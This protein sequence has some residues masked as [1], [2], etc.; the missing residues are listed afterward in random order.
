M[1]KEVS[2][3]TLTLQTKSTAR[4]IIGF[5]VGTISRCVKMTFRYLR[6]CRNFGGVGKYISKKSIEKTNVIIIDLR[7]SIINY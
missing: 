1:E 2:P 7:F 6:K 3:Y 4:Y 5:S